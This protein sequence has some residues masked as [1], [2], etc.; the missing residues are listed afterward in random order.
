[1]PV[2]GIVVSIVS[3]GHGEL[4]AALASNLVQLASIKAI[5]ITKNISEHIA[6]PVSEKI[7]L[8]RN[9]RPKGFGANHN[10]AFKLCDQPYFC[11]INPDVLFVGDPFEWLVQIA[12]A[13]SAAL[14]APRIVNLEG[15]DEDSFRSFPTVLSLLRK[16]LTGHKGIAPLPPSGHLV[17]PDWIAG[18]F[19]LFTADSYRLVGGFDE[20]FYMYYE[21]VDICARLRFLGQKILVDMSLSIMHSAQRASHRRLRHAIWHLMSML[22]Y[23][24]RYR[25]KSRAQALL[26][27]NSHFCQ[28]RA[29]CD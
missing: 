11:V 14:I 24:W 25:G 15:D 13:E 29:Q 5:I 18:A 21:D 7:I 16:A 17:S 27:Q 6:L 20:R 8:L 10:C 2:S 19:M 23:F 28:N 3:H 9:E 26:V 4:V 1:M 22:R 12:R